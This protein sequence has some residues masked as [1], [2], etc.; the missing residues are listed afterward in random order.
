M[1]RLLIMMMMLGWWQSMLVCAVW[2]MSVPTTH[3]STAWL[4]KR[5]L[6]SKESEKVKPTYFMRQNIPVAWPN[7]HQNQPSQKWKS[8]Y[9][10]LLL[11]ATTQKDNLLHKCRV[12]DNHGMISQKP[13]NNIQPNIKD[14][15][16]QK[17]RDHAEPQPDVFSLPSSHLGFHKE[18]EYS[19]I[20]QK[21][22]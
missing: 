7:R 11:G 21:H 15:Q 17:T 14:I 10:F 4:Q 13:L 6:Q 16:C 22:Q 12:G 18:G 3:A 2:S 5:R 20:I 19:K 8:F 1:M 9:S